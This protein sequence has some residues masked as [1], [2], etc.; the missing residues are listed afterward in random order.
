MIG[1]EPLLATLRES[2]LPVGVAELARLRQVFALEPQLPDGDADIRRLKAL[3]RA[4]LVKST[5]DRV[6]FERIV[7]AWLGRAGQD[8]SLRERAA[9][10]RPAVPVQQAP[11]PW[12]QRYRWRA[13]TAVV[14]C[15][16]SFALGGHLKVQPIQTIKVSDVKPTRPSGPVTPQPAAL[17]PDD[18]RKRTFTT[19]VPTLTM[20]PAKPVWQ[21][22]P[23][24][25]L[26]LL[27]L[28][29]AGGLWLALRKRSWY[30]PPAPQPSKKGPPRV[31]LAPPQLA[32]PQL[33]APREEE[34]LVWGIGHFVAEEPT[35][36]LD[37]PATVRATARAAGLPEL[38]FHQARY[39]REVW[40]WLDEAADDPAVQRLAEE[41]ESA[42]QAHGLAVERAHFRGVPDRLVTAAGQIFAP[43]E[44]D[45]RRDAALVAILTDGRILARH[46]AADDRR[47]RLAALLRSLSHW[48][49]LAFV[50]FS[51]GLSGL[52]AILP[53][54]SLARI[55]PME[56]AAFLGS[57]ETLQRRAVTGTESDAVWAAACALAPSSVDELR[58]F[59]LRRRLGLAVSPWALR[60]L[61]AEAPGPP[62]RLQWRAPDRARR[63][64]WLREAEDQAEDG[65]ASGSLLGRALGFWEKVYDQE[66]KEKPA[67]GPEA[68]LE[69][70]PAHQHLLME[71]ALLGLWRQ[72]DA[73]AAVRDLYRLHSGALREPIEQ[74]L[75]DLAPLDWGGPEHVHLPWVWEERSGAERVMLQ[76]MKLGGGMPAATLQRPGRLWLGIAICLGLAVGALAAA[77]K[78]GRRLPDG[79]PDL[80]L[81]P[82]RPA[83][84]L[85]GVA[86]ASAEKWR[87]AVATRKSLASTEVAPRAKVRV[88]WQELSL[89]CVAVLSGGGAE[90]WSCG[91]V[92]APPRLSASIGRRVL[93]LAT[94]PG[95]SDAEALAV[96]LLDSGSADV[97]LISSDWLRYRSLLTGILAAGNEFLVL[98]NSRWK[99]LSR[100]LRFE[101]IRTI[102]QV[103]P[104][105]KPLA[106]D[107]T[108][109][110]RGLSSCSD[111]L[112]YPD[113]V[114]FV[115][116]CSAISIHLNQVGGRRV[117][118]TS[119]DKNETNGSWIGSDEISTRQYNSAPEQGVAA[120]VSW[121]AASGYCERHGWHLPTLDESVTA[122]FSAGSDLTGSRVATGR[123]EL[124]IKKGPEDRQ[125]GTRLRQSDWE[126]VGN[127][128]GRDDTGLRTDRA[129]EGHLALG[130]RE[131]GAEGIEIIL[132]EESSQ[133]HI[134]HHFRCALGTLP[135]GK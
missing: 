100:T 92:A 20:T 134:T 126:W 62:G 42:L 37:L 78:S 59:E 112:E 121:F 4:V 94:V 135:S 46:Y 64:N 72:H 51:A 111:T 15:V 99:E 58:A 60:A 123:I 17:T 50:D 114:V 7:E 19:W 28:A 105:V 120:S 76:E 68:S 22:W 69:G 132:I 8:L 108:A 102:R 36:R 90:V 54:H 93:V 38:R 82:G 30:P 95:V 34:A 44:V 115:H 43:N 11:K 125:S 133:P 56:L 52:A 32:G 80:I 35:R 97:V 109:L 48:P 81:G 128:L 65:P 6:T 49:R 119:V 45:E 25:A 33:L 74:H 124:M 70:T 21:G 23:P 5:E 84:V 31:F 103:W 12:Q 116:L 113:G 91:T 127:D 63:V 61:R 57:D 10:E 13:L 104:D 47:V 39:P 67:A 110:L 98:P 26:G 14:L 40:L 9:P 96:D 2:G 89:P 101:G 41:I 29:T 107:P 87:V 122:R 85:Q 18:I 53:K 55:T 77:A 83:E 1:L 79:P 106:G 75:P 118:V 86:R 3:L 66:L 16:L 24:L 131:I 129:S 130:A 71:R 27:A 88:K 117:T 73:P